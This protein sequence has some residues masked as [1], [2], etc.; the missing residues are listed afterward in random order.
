MRW[1]I[2]LLVAAVLPACSAD[3]TTVDG[4]VGYTGGVASSG[5]GNPFDQV[6]PG[7]VGPDLSK[8]DSE[9]YTVP[10]LLPQLEDPEIV[11]SLEG[12][13]VELIDEATGFHKVYPTGVGA[14]ARNGQSFT[15]VGEFNTLDD[16]SNGWYW[17]AR[18]YEPEYFDGLP[19]MRITAENH[20]GYH[21]YGFHG[22]ITDTLQRGFVSH[23]CMRMQG[24]DIVELFYLMR[25]HA[26]SKV[27]IQLDKRRWDD[28]SVVDV[29]PADQDPVAAWRASLCAS[30]EHGQGE[31]VSTGTYTDR[32]LCGGQASYRVAAVAGERVVARVSASGP[33][34]LR[35]EGADATETIS[36]FTGDTHLAE[37]SLLLPADGEITVSV[38]GE[39]AWYSL[40]LERLAAGTVPP[41]DRWIGAGCEADLQCGD[42]VCD[43]SVPGGL[44]TE[45]C[46][47]FCPDREGEA[48]TFC[49]DLGFEDGG[50][51]VSACSADSDCRAG[52]RCAVV[53]RHGE[54]QTRRAACVPAE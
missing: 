10:A 46:D 27:S 44:C 52:W 15:P 43:Q 33:V 11:V 34:T 38:I 36:D 19:F 7:A 39:P 40:S 18:R 45:V 48:S 12:F 24:P 17:Y 53:G 47:R 32:V 26:G 35:L 22:P 23:G 50:R 49:V 3:E 5:G 41:E 25:P 6:N 9:A 54:P 8:A 28:G 1:T 2:G 31:L 14:L 21:T 29:T 13:T 20:R 16:A 51:C 4:D 37:A 30:A 42:R